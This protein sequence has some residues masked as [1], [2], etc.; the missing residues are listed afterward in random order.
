MITA[1]TE[2][3]NLS[4]NELVD[5][6][7]NLEMQDQESYIPKKKDKIR[8]SD[9]KSSNDSNSTSQD[10]YCDRCKVFEGEKALAW[11]N[12]TTA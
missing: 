11:K 4:I 7:E 2:P 9:S 8:N 5:H 12:H 1:K 10:V 6:L 3:R